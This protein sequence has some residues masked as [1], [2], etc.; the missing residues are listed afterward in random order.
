MCA[1]ECGCVGVC[2]GGCVC[3][4]RECGHV[5]RV[6]EGVCVDVRRR[7]Q[8]IYNLFTASN[9]FQCIVHCTYIL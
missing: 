9:Q 3:C 8:V 1:R 5:L 2:A 4:G 7:N 6:C